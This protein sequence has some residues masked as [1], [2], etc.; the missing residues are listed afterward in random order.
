MAA[1]FIISIDT[2][3]KWGY[4]FYPN[5]PMARMLQSNEDKA[6]AVVD[7]LLNL[8]EKFRGTR[9]LGYRRKAVL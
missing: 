9:N 4:R 6:I 8:F 3:L 1:H 2:E 5:S 7:A